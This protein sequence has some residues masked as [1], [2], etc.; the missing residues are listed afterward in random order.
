MRKN[1]SREAAL[2]ERGRLCYMDI[3]IL[4]SGPP[5]LARLVAAGSDQPG[6]ARP[7]AGAAHPAQAGGHAAVA[8]LYQE[9][10]LGLVR[11]AHIMLGDKTAAEDVVQEAFFGLYRR[12]ALLSDPARALQYTRSAVLNGCRSVLRHRARH[13]Q[14]GA[15]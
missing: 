5:G 7:D 2:C 8:Q 4:D 10:S 9:H 3:D 13:G 15:W 6:R 12:W 14:P 1:R 11:L